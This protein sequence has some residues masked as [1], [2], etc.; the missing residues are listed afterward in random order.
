M[1]NL[2]YDIISYT[3]VFG[4]I[5]TIWYFMFDSAMNIPDVHVSNSTGECVEVINW[6]EEDNY[7]CEELPS[8]YNHVW[9]K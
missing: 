8:K 2:V 4:M 9:V 5:G 6:N 7:S 3:V 1:R